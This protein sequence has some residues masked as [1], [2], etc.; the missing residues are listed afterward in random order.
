MSHRDAT[1]AWKIIKI[2]LVTYPQFNEPPVRQK[3]RSLLNGEASL[4]ISYR[5]SVQHVDPL[6]DCSIST[7]SEPTNAVLL[8]LSC[9]PD[10]FSPPSINFPTLCLFT[11][12]HNPISLNARLFAFLI[13]WQV[14]ER[15]ER[16][17]LRQKLFTIVQRLHLVSISHR[18]SESVY[19][20]KEAWYRV[21]WE[22]SAA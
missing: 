10:T 12:H 22:N 5:S 7:P 19:M 21:S 14:W 15:R 2:I 6:D 11:H 9:F 4:S 16:R 13:Y 8:E 18:S 17:K 20:C 1:N 3:K